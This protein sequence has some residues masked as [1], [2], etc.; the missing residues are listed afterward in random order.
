MKV[1][2][3]G[4][5]EEQEWDDLIYSIPDADVYFTAGYCR[6]YEDNQEG[7]AQLFVY[8]EAENLICYPFLLRDISSQVSFRH[9][10]L[11]GPIY[12]ISTPYGYGGPISNVSDPE[13]RHALYRDFELQFAAYCDQKRIVTEFVRFHPL[14]RN[15]QDYL[16]A[17][18]EYVRDTIYID[19]TPD[20]Q[21]MMSRYSKDN[22]NRIRRAEKE[23]LEVRISPLTQLEDL[24][25]LYYST[26]YKK[27]AS[28]Y[29][30]FGR[31]FFENT[32]QHLHDHI[33]L[34]QVWR[35][36]RVI[37]SCLFMHY[38][39]YAHYHLMGSDQEHLKC[40]PVNL[41]IHKAALWAKSLGCKMLHLGGG[42][43]GNDSLF[44]FKRSFNEKQEANFYVGKRIRDE[45]LYAASIQGVGLTLLQNN[46]FPAYRNP[47]LLRTIE[48]MLE[49]AVAVL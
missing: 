25:R 40:A 16:D 39:N 27:Q 34:I 32:V 15:E 41:L 33:Q 28:S 43:T 36:D 20:E 22:R 18:P 49:Q 38:G 12:D 6:I 3:L 8:Q 31:E 26:M 1:R 42:Y 13:R 45:E 14:L 44:R 21:T 30:Y 19:L 46:Y 47:D 5:D 11:D 7:K 9:M 24:L 29:Y 48:G 2:I 4:I 23:G 35:E 10:Q 17:K 37:S